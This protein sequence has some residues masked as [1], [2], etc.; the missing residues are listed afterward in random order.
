MY[1]SDKN[2]NINNHHNLKYE[3][4]VNTKNDKK[5]KLNCNNKKNII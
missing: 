1:Y 4:S 2:K 5:E 3:N